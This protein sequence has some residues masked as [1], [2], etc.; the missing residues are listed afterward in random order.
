[1][2]KFI[3]IC[4]VFII[5]ALAYF[6]LQQHINIANDVIGADKQANMNRIKEMMLWAMIASGALV[7]LFG[8]DLLNK[9]EAAQ[10]LGTAGC[11]CDGSSSMM[12]TMP[13]SLPSVPKGVLSRMYEF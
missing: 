2:F 10:Y 9:P 13:S 4:V 1:M 12:Q 8:Y 5:T 7:L 3:I 11:G 6:R